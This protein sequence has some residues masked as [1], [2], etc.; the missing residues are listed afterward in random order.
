MG[1]DDHRRFTLRQ[2]AVFVS[3]AES[4]SISGASGALGMSETSVSSTL[5][6][7]E[8]TLGLR[9][10]IR[11][12]ARGV[13]LTTHGRDVL[14]RARTLLDAAEDLH[15]DLAAQHSRLTGVVRVGVM[16][17]LAPS[18]APPVVDA[19]RVRHPGV[20][21]DLVLGSQDDL[22]GRLGTEIDL[23]VVLG[24]HLPRSVP[25]RE[26]F[27]VTVHAILPADH[28]LAARSSVA[29]RDLVHEPLLLVDTPASV[30]H[31]YAMYESIGATPHVGFRSSSFEV[32]RSLVGRGLG[33]SLQ[34]LRPHGDHTYEGLPL[35]VRPID[36][37]DLREIVVIAWSA[38]VRPSSRALALIDLTAEALDTAEVRS[39]WS[40]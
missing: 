20:V 3:V 14:D 29:L 24:R 37:V 36:D 39:A 6:D 31:A 27:E 7:L 35:A 40:V 30:E 26:V 10:C 9:L 22:I 16:A 33:F 18:L 19:C 28:P 5:T 12:R 23:A 32:T 17:G 8:R 25:R 1:F 15:G 38:E 11:R 4:G 34:V 13:E 2:L 21:I